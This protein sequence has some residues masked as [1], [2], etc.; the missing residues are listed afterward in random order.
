MAHFPK[1]LERLIEAFLV[2]PGIG[3]RTAQRFAFS[4]LEGNHE[5]AR[6]L[7]SALEQL[8]QGLLV[9]ARCGQYSERSPCALCAD[10]TRTAAELCIVAESR[11][12]FPLEQTG[13]F[14]GLYFVLGGLI[15]PLEGLEPERLRLE[16]LV[17]RLREG[18]VSE[19]ILALNP[20]V[21][22]DTT[23]LYLARRLKPFAVKLTRLARGLPTGAHLEYADEA[24]LKSALLNR[25]AVNA[26]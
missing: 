19:V 26:G 8:H 13:L 20:D 17:A 15:N 12:I 21:E 5:R 6:E 4:L 9:C 23:A 16:A 3:R 1:P 7:A 14:R 24:T 22:G 2:L 25:R 10:T 11:D 18:G